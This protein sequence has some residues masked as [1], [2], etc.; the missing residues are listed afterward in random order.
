M[1]DIEKINELQ[2]IYYV[3]KN[4]HIYRFF[5]STF[6]IVD[7]KIYLDY[8]AT[9]FEPKDLFESE[10]DANLYKENILETLYKKNRS[11]MNEPKDII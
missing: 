3:D 6:K 2:H 8:F 7:N 9:Y 11:N 5:K 10:K 1:I 4:L